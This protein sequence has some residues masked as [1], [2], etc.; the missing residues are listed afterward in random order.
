MNDL[1]LSPINV[2]LTVDLSRCEVNGNFS[3]KSQ[4]LSTLV[5]FE[6]LLKGFLFELGTSAWNQKTRMMGRERS[7]RI[8]SDVWIQYR[9]VTDRQTDGRTTGN[10]EECAYA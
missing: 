10:S 6:P 1:L 9:N 2:P 7:L 8:S 4:N 5:Y 3:R